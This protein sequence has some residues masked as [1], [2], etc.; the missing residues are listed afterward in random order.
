MS[1]VFEQGAEFRAPSWYQ[2]FDPV[3]GH[4]HV[5]HGRTNIPLPSPSFGDLNRA[6]RNMYYNMCCAKAGVTVQLCCWIFGLPLVT[7]HSFISTL[8]TITF[9]KT[10]QKNLQIHFS[11]VSLL[12]QRSSRFQLCRASMTC[13]HV[14]SRTGLTWQGIGRHLFSGKS[15]TRFL[16]VSL[17]DQRLST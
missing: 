17:L 5:M 6:L 10:F 15:K 11:Q 8:C 13:H 7:G 4:R 12:Y 1:C 16:C 3:N 9:S 14:S 2:H